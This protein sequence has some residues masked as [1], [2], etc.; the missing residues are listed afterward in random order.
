MEIYIKRGFF[1]NLSQLRQDKSLEQD[2]WSSFW[3]STPNYAYLREKKKVSSFVLYVL[4][5]LLHASLPF[6]K[7]MTRN[8]KSLSAH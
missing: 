2:Y 4:S 3:M 5:K 8:A 7:N 1:E 6:D